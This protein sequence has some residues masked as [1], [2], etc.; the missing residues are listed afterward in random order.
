MEAV[1]L[2]NE[3][4]QILCA[5]V[6]QALVLEAEVEQTFAGRTL[7]QPVGNDLPQKGGLAGTAHAD[8]GHGLVLD[9]GQPHI[10]PGELRHRRRDGIHDLLSNDVAHLSSMVGQINE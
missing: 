5:D 9:T 1:V 4:T 10:A 3:D 8:D 7:R 2:L 6:R